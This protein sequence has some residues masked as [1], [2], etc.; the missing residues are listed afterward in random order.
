[1]G[2]ERTG[3]KTF[4]ILFVILI[5]ISES[6]QYRAP[7]PGSKKQGPPAGEHATASQVC[8]HARCYVPEHALLSLYLIQGQA[9]N[10]DEWSGFL[11]S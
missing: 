2:V 9:A 7:L 8:L 4:M 3:S 1:M 5:V 6:L 10:Q 11:I